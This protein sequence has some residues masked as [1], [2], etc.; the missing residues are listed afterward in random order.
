MASPNKDKKP[1]DPGLD[2]VT[3]IALDKIR[4]AGARVAIASPAAA[5]APLLGLKPGAVFKTVARRLPGLNTAI[6]LGIGG[7]KLLER[8]QPGAFDRDAERGDEYLKQPGPGWH[9]TK[10]AISPADY[11]SAVGASRERDAKKRFEAKVDNKGWQ[12]IMDA[13]GRK[14][15][16]EEAVKLAKSNGLEKYHQDPTPEAHNKWAGKNHGNI[17]KD[18]FLKLPPADFMKGFR[19]QRRKI[20]RK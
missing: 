6:E 20:V 3:D 14:R 19:H 9:V 11:F 1:R 10:A 4:N 5:V 7:H 8:G 13:E 18:G 17:D 15:A 12:R 16:E 2:L